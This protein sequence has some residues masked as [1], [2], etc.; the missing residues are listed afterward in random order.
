MRLSVHHR[1][2]YDY[3]GHVSSSTQY[4]RLTPV[5]NPSQRVL[6]WRIEAP[7]PLAEWRDAFGNVCHTL[8]VDKPVSSIDIH[9]HGQ[10]DTTDTSGVLP[11]EFDGP[12]LDVFL[13]E[14]PL[15]RADEQVRDFAA[16]YRAKLEAGRLD[17]LH[18]L[19][20][21]VRD[22]VDYRSG[23]T[24]VHSSA[25]ESLELGTGV[26][27]DHAH[28]FIACC[29]H[30][31]VPARYVSGYLFTPDES[32]VASHAWAAAWIDDLGWVS[33][34]VANRTCGTPHHIGLAVG[35]DYHGAAPARGVRQGGDDGETLSVFVRI[36]ESQRQQQR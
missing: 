32:E 14:T 18:A 10:V 20:G 5:S 17:G 28:V 36:A 9:A 12:P 15:T 27:Q 6:N 29:R 4:L 8:V 31:G 33:F 30:L 34:D 2:S 23:G 25:S 26:C 16:P 3:D 24:D 13:R 21:A 22:A 19:S 11:D 1:T 35:L 7:G